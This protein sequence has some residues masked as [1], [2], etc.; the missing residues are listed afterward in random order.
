MSAG[1][2]LPP[3]VFMK[4][5]YQHMLN[6]T[7]QMID[8]EDW[9]SICDAMKADNY[10]PS[11]LERQIVDGYVDN[12]YCDL[13]DFTEYMDEMSGG[14]SGSRDADKMFKDFYS[15]IYDRREYISND[16]ARRLGSA[17]RDYAQARDLGK[18][19]KPNPNRGIDLAMI[20]GTGIETGWRGI[21]DEFK[22]SG[23]EPSILETSAIDNMVALELSDVLDWEDEIDEIGFNIEE[24]IERAENAGVSPKLRYGQLSEEIVGDL[25]YCRNVRGKEVFS[26][27]DTLPVAEDKVLTATDEFVKAQGAFERDVYD[28]RQFISKDITDRM[29]PNYGHYKDGVPPAPVPAASPASFDYSKSAGTGAGKAKDVEKA[30]PAPS[31]RKAAG[32]STVL[33]GDE[34]DFGD[35]GG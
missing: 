19:G 28:R 7:E 8:E 4:G 26:D 9:Q 13:C 31:V 24:A 20:E 3:A 22:A 32:F 35:L 18:G 21:C 27:E 10:A 17:Y 5:C 14:R 29:S 11:K 23:Y 12:A 16:Q 34:D 30:K 2:V 15:A 6:I 33:S 1:G 25:S